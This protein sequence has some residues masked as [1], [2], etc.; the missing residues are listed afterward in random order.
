MQRKHGAFFFLPDAINGVG[1]AIF[2]TFN[3]F[4]NSDDSVVSV[5]CGVVELPLLMRLVFCGVDAPAVELPFVGIRNLLLGAGTIF[6]PWTRFT[7]RII[8]SGAIMW[9]HW[10]HNTIG[11]GSL[12]DSP[13]KLQSCRSNRWTSAREWTKKNKLRNEKYEIEPHLLWLR[14]TSIFSASFPL[15]I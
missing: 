13:Y 2:E 11:P 12:G 6:E 4:E 3:R 7:C 5:A 14:M 10:L 15:L 9:L 8:P 1:G